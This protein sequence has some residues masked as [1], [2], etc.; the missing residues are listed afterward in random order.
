MTPVWY[1]ETIE[2]LLDKN[3]HGGYI[4]GLDIA[5][6]PET[7]CGTKKY[8]YIS[9]QIFFRKELLAKYLITRL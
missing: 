8:K 2:L 5:A 7:A 3:F 1:T 6:L 4:A 9:I